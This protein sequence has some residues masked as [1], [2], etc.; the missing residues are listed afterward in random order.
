MCLQF[1]LTQG[2]K[3]KYVANKNILHNSRKIKI[4]DSVSFDE[5]TTEKLLKSGVISLAENKIDKK[6]KKQTI[7]KE[8][9]VIEPESVETEKFKED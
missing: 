8:D 2:F 7:K 6:S 3:M 1:N 9:M 5:I 4:G